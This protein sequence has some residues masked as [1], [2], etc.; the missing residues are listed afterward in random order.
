M[1]K[2]GWDWEKTPC[3]CRYSIGIYYENGIAT[4]IQTVS[5]VQEFN[6]KEHA[7]YI[8]GLYKQVQLGENNTVYIYA[9]GPFDIEF[10][11]QIMPYK[12]FTWNEKTPREYNYI[13]I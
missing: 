4:K 2:Q 5:G 8:R 10:I 7:M 11:K 1:L 6:A 3:G 13:I 9:E 12:H